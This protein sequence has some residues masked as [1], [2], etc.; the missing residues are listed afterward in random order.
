MNELGK[1][2]PTTPARAGAF[3]RFAQTCAR[4]ASRPITVIVAGLSDLLPRFRRQRLPLYY[5]RAAA[6]N[7]VRE[8]HRVNQFHQTFQLIAIGSGRLCCPS[9]LGDARSVMMEL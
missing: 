7:A 5:D 6:K 9:L 2:H 4:L 1:Q 3:T 8:S